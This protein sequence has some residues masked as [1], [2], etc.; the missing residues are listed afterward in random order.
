MASQLKVNS[1]FLR[2][3]EQFNQQEFYDCH[4]TL[5]DVWRHDES[6]ERE[7]IQGII[8]IAVG[9][10]HCLRGNRAGAEKLLN[11]GLYRIK[12]F[13]NSCDYLDIGRL[14]KDVSANIEE[15]EQTPNSICPSLKLPTIEVLTD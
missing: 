11:R 14:A 4:E 2:G 13:E 8:Q 3:L 1:E 5:E 15:I 7:M 6:S 12:K 10:Y 9:Y